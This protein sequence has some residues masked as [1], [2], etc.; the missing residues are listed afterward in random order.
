MLA[1]TVTQNPYGTINPQH[2]GSRLLESGAEF[3]QKI[4]ALFQEYWA[5]YITARKS[6]PPTSGEHKS[7]PLERL[8]VYFG[9]ECVYVESH[10]AHTSGP[11]HHKYS[12]KSI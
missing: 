2:I 11:S 8:C 5:G 6:L 4:P 1:R 3:D 7:L 10:V 9:F 12:G